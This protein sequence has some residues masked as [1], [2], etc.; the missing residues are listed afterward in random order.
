M[1]GVRRSSQEWLS[2]VRGWRA[3]GLSRSAY[4]EA[5]GL[6]VRQ[7]HGWVARLRPLRH[8]PLP[9]DGAPDLRFLRVEVAGATPRG[10]TLTPTGAA[11]AGSVEIQM[12]AMTVR[13]IGALDADL[14]RGVLGVVRTLT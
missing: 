10:A 5:Q 9:A 11:R 6:D 14:L 12:G 7:F 3:S 8:R 1:A 2:H 13:V 4:C